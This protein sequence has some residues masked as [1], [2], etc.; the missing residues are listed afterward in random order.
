LFVF[1]RWSFIVV[2]QTGDDAQ[3]GNDDATHDR[4][5]L[6]II[7]TGEQPDTQVIGRVDF[8]AVHFHACIG[9]QDFNLGKPL[10]LYVV[11]GS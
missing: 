2:A 5:L 11:Q 8:A 10:C 1:L 4:V 3:P 6:E 7:S 9:V